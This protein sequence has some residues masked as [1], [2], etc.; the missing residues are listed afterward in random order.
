MDLTDRMTTFFSV[1]YAN[2]IK[3]R[4]GG[5]K[6]RREPGLVPTIGENH[7][8]TGN[9]HYL[10]AKTLGS[11]NSLLMAMLMPDAIRLTGDEAR[12]Q[13]LAKLIEAHKDLKLKPEELLKLSN[14]VD[15]NAQYYG[16]YYGRRNLKDKDHSNFRPVPTWSSAVGIPPLPDELR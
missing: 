3:E 5:R 11:H 16:S 13:R 1:S 15:T 12:Q 7:P 9:V 8:K 6:D 2:L 14:W 10:P 4:R